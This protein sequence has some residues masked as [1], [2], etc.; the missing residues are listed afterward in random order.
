MIHQFSRR[1]FL[2]GIGGGAVSASLV[3]GVRE[4]VRRP[5]PPGDHAVLAACCAYAEHDG[6]LVTTEDKA[7]LRHA[8][9]YRSGWHPLE[10]NRTRAWRWTHQSAT[11][12]F[13]NP[14]VD[15]RFHLDYE[16]R[17]SLFAS[18]PR[19]ATLSIGDR[20]LHS[21]VVDAARRNQLAVSLPAAELGADDVTELQLTV[22]RTF[23]PAELV[24]R[25]TDRRR[26]GIL[27]L[28]ASIETAAVHPS[29]SP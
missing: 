2:M 17:P 10:L 11:L 19:R 6:W 20:V 1:V 18:A 16:G 27:V 26:L 14:R 24:P 28:Q 9:T 21:F 4:S 8:V 5:L 22:D 23:V 3:W 12:S 29:Q 13:P 7:H 25:L 15:I